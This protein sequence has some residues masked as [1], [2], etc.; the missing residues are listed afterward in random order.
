MET[1][2]GPLWVYLGGFEAP[3]VY[4]VGGGAA[5]L[6]SLAV[7]RYVYRCILKCICMCLYTHSHTHL[8]PIHI[9]TSART[10]YMLTCNY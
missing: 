7:H 3:S 10:P 5:L 2:L 4:A 9:P 1:A 8:L 6:V